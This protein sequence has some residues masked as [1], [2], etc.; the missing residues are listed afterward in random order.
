MKKITILFAILCFAF[1]NQTQA[2]TLTGNSLDLLA[3]RTDLT[4]NITEETLTSG[5]NLTIDYTAPTARINWDGLTRVAPGDIVTVYVEF[6]EEMA[7][8]PIPQISGS[9][10]NT[11]A[12][13][14]LVH[15]DQNRIYTYTWTVG[16]SFGTQYF[17]VSTG[18]DLAGNITEETLTSGGSIL[19]DILPTAALSYTVNGTS[20][21][22]VKQ[23][24]EVL[25]TATFNKD[26]VDIPVVQIYA[27]E[28][29]SFSATNM[30]KISSTSYTYTH[31][32]G[33]GDGNQ[34]FRLAT[35]TDLAGNLINEVPTSGGTLIIDNTAPSAIINWEVTTVNPGNLITINVEFSEEM[36]NSPV[37]QISGSG[38]N[39]FAA[40]DLVHDG[41]N[42][43]KYSWTVED[44]IGLQFFSVSTGTDIAGNLT[45]ETLTSGAS[46]FI[47][48]PASGSLVYTVSGNVED[49]PVQGDVV[50]ITATFNNE[51]DVNHTM[52]IKGTG[53]QSLLGNMERLTSK[54][55]TYT[56][57]VDIG[58]G[59]T[60]F[61]FQNG[62][63][64][65]GNSI[66]YDPS[67]GVSIYHNPSVLNSSHED[68]EL[69]N[70]GAIKINA[71]LVTGDITLSTVPLNDL[72]VQWNKEYLQ[73][74]TTK[75]NTAFNELYD[76]TNWPGFELARITKAYDPTHHG[77]A[78]PGAAL[79]QISA[80]P[81][82]LENYLNVL[83]LDADRDFTDLAG[84]TTL[85]SSTLSSHGA[86]LYID[87]EET[88]FVLTH[89]TGHVVG[90][91]HFAGGWPPE[92]INFVL[93]DGTTM[94]YH[95]LNNS[96]AEINFMG[97]W[98]STMEEYL[99]DPSGALAAGIE[100]ESLYLTK[101]LMTFKTPTFG[102]VSSEV[103]RS[104]LITNEYILASAPNAGYGGH[105]T[106]L[107]VSSNWENEGDN[108]FSSFS[109]QTYPE[110]V[111]SQNET[112][113]YAAI[114]F[115]DT[116][117]DQL[118]Y[119]YRDN[120]SEWGAVT[121]IQGTDGEFQNYEMA[122]NSK[123]DVII[124]TEPSNEGT[125]K[126][127]SKAVDDVS[128]TG[129]LVISDSG[130]NKLRTSRVKVSI[131]AA[132]NAVAVWL[133]RDN[134]GSSDSVT[135]YDNNYSSIV[136]KERIA[137]TWSSAEVLSLDNSKNDLPSIAYNDKGDVLVSW[138]QY[139]NSSN[140]YE[141]V[142]KFRNGT[143]NV[144]SSVES[145]GE[146]NS[147]S[148]F[149]QVAIDV[150]GNALVYWR[151]AGIPEEREIL[152][153][154]P[155]TGF[156]N[157]RYRNLDG[158]LENTTQLTPTEKDAFNGATEQNENRVIFLEDGSAAVTWWVNDGT[159][160]NTIYASSMQSKNVWTT[161]VAL[162]N[163]GH[164]ATLSKIATGN[165]GDYSVIWQR[166]DGLNTR[167][168][169]RTYHAATSNWSAIS[170]LSNSGSNALWGDIASDGDNQLSTI[171]VR[172][173][174]SNW[175][176][177]YI[178]EV[179]RLSL[180][181]FI[182]KTTITADNS[183][184]SVSFNEAVYNTNGAPGSLEANDFTLS[185]SGGTATLASTTP[186]SIS[187]NANVY[188]LGVSFT[189][190]P[191]GTETLTVVP[192]SIGA[193]FDSAGNQAA[194][195]Q[196]NNSIALNDMTT[197]T[198]SLVYTVS[199]DIVRR[200]SENDAVTIT[201]T[202]NKE[203]ADSP[204]VQ[205]SGTGVN[206][207]SASNM[208][209][210]SS[211][212]YTYT[213]TVGEGSG[214]QNFELETGTNLE[215]T[216][217]TA[218]PSSGATIIVVD[219]IVPTA[220]LNYTKDN[221]SVNTVKEGDNILITAIFNEP[222]ADFP[223]VQL[224]SSGVNNMIKRN[225]T[226]VSSTEYIYL[227][228]VGSGNGTQNFIIESATDLGGAVVAPT[229]S[230]G[231][232]IIIDNTKPEFVLAYT[233]D[234]TSVS[235]V[236]AGDEVLITATFDEVMADSPV[237][238]ISGKLSFDWDSIT[239]A[240]SSMIKVSSTKYTYLWTVGSEDG[241]N[242]FD[243]GIG[244]DIA[245]NIVER[246]DMSGGFVTIDNTRPT[247]QINWDGLTRVAPGD[248]VTVYV[249]FSEEM[250]NSPVPQISGSGAN[251]F[252]ATD[253]VHDSQ[254]KIY[255]YAWTVGGNFGTQTFSVSTGTD[256]VGNLTVETLTSGGS[257]TVGTHNTAALSYTVNNNPIQAVKQG[258]EVR[259]TATFN[260]EIRVDPIPQIYAEGL[261][262]FSATNMTR[263]SSTSYTY[264]F[265]AG[266]GDGD[267]NFR[268]ATGLN[269]AGSLINSV[270]SS[271]D[272]LIIDNTK[273]TI[274][275]LGDASIPLE[276]GTSY[277]DDGATAS[278]SRD[279]T[280]TS[281]IITVN[282]V[283]INADGVYT[284][285]YNVSD[286]VGNQ[287]VEVERTVTVVS[288]PEITLTGDALVTVEVGSTYNDEGATAYDDYDG[289]IS[290]IINVV[291]NVNVDALGSY[292]VTYD[293]TDANGNSAVTVTR[294]VN[295]V[296][297]AVPVLPVI[298]LLGNASVFVE[299]GTAYTDAGATASDSTGGI[300][301]SSIVITGT[302]D[303]N[304]VGNYTLFYNVSDAA[305]NPATQVSRT[306]TVVNYSVPVITLLGDAIISLRRGSTY[307]D[308]GAT[309]TDNTDGTITN[310]INT[311]N[312]VNINAFGTYTIT[313]NV[314]NS[315][316]A[317]AIQVTRTVVVQGDEDYCDFS[318]NFENF[319]LTGWTIFNSNTESNNIM[320]TDA[321]SK[322]GNYS[323]R[324]SSKDEDSAYDQYLLSPEFTPSDIEKAI[325]FYYLAS[326]VG[327]VE[328]FKVG[329]STTGNN[330]DTDFT[331]SDEI[332]AESADDLNDMFEYSKDD[333]PIG[334][335]Y[336]A[337]HYYSDNKNHLYI[338]RFCLLA[339][340]EGGYN[341]GITLLGA[342]DVSIELGTTYTDAGAIAFNE[343]GVD[344]TADIITINP[345]DENLEGIYTITYNASDPE[346]NAATEVT[347]TVTVFTSMW[348]GNVDNNWNTAA[349]WSSNAVPS[350]SA[351][352]RIPKT[353]I[354]NFPT[355]LTD[356]NIHAITIESGASLIAAASFSGSLTYK[357]NLYLADSWHFITSPVE[358]TSLADVI[359]NTDLR[360]GTGPNIGIS[361]YDNNVPGWVYH[362][363]TSSG[364]MDS[365]K[366][367][368]V[369]VNSGDIFFTG[370]M[371]IGP[372]DKSLT[373]GQDGWNLI[374]NPY[375]SYLAINNSADAINFLD[376]NSSSL[377]NNFSSIY[378]WDVLDTQS[379]I[380]VVNHATESYDMAPGQ[381]FFVNVDSDGNS[382]SFTNE[383]QSHQAIEN[384]YRSPESTPT[385]VLAI[386]NTEDL[387][388]TTIKYFDSTTAGLDIGY[389][390]G[391][392]NAGGESNFKLNTHLVEDS[393]GIDFMLQC[394]SNNEYETSVVP[395]AVK[396]E[397]GLEI[398]FSV[399]ASNLPE[400]IKVFLEDKTTNTYTRLDEDNSEYIVALTEAENGIGRFYL[401]TKS[402]VLN[403]ND[404]YLNVI[405]IYKKNSSTIRI[406]G[407]AEGTTNF[408]LFNTLGVPVKKTS[409]KAERVFDIEI[410]RLP[411]GI[412]VVQLENGNRIVNKK[413]FLE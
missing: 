71:I 49:Y 69:N 22:K 133:R 61:G 300:I 276:F 388:T 360:T 88:E 206:N 187:S 150:N 379:G 304:T 208:T 322:D 333:L 26:M 301:T 396:A 25:I 152:A 191:N 354:T 84:Q 384:F 352:V 282:T 115:L 265:T 297:A 254:N 224:S 80:Q 271:G 163:S 287:A 299:L 380:K 338:D 398:V 337:I 215:G 366:G 120:N 93:Q 161:P 236:T 154:V 38:A 46:I 312:P 395:L 323:L 225:M 313:Y 402:S 249:E 66:T 319:P 197:H 340:P 404:P 124:I 397:A 285:T 270:P 5:K 45:E 16:Q 145:Y 263:I 228:T 394:L 118:N 342:E 156:L 318:E 188:T 121:T 173:N 17:S 257:I 160:P 29:N 186:T 222:M 19:I 159:N 79:S 218:T 95:T 311:V 113:N 27:E 81:V 94:G 387:E 77:T 250:A 220:A 101:P 153:A 376:V 162:S 368:A 204:I 306:V 334:T 295:V 177:Y 324:F 291:S 23:G 100:T 286:A 108:V 371:P 411:A 185:I 15:D 14:D 234:G 377:S 181:P 332:I 179:K 305:G 303:N 62:K 50:T 182:T 82:A 138:Q 405:S 343:Q 358:G 157:V 277:T 72:G 8:S 294:T 36:A 201:A 346:G 375:P 158:S 165:G 110:I 248:V 31:T 216:V 28:L 238:Q 198:A 39:T 253:L 274:E 359:S 53:A 56:Y 178:P 195:M 219:N 245:G 289:N 194:T 362:S 131:N 251:T 116:T 132:G 96:Q 183:A 170:T 292:T 296:A 11:I 174:G 128:W 203:I 55:Y 155:R 357:R 229:P 24:D 329:W 97:A 193:I 98:N 143:T 230:S 226:K 103:F 134:D 364:T 51:I 142:G 139:N 78:D 393:E 217:I 386:D 65:Y 325:S 151:Q 280:I 314:S 391:A 267:Q 111:T 125:I 75:M 252:A 167:I 140:K 223:F 168:Q 42:K 403:I 164:N 92:N 109:R 344:I 372:I 246:S 209:K 214:V 227:W 148:G 207:I 10:A 147:S 130:M 211:K 4:G 202:F 268:L 382:V 355:A 410:P 117:N 401:H 348:N 180:N 7:N 196:N 260:Q 76:S 266:S 213:W 122:M 308:A 83:V 200:V 406:V 400:G 327:E 247:A 339:S 12:V 90:L 169:T 233:I 112:N 310:H 32:A 105:D 302:V 18:T 104:W 328:V 298:R 365:A 269:E 74:I 320:L 399:E 1:F 146:T 284:I 239:L 33:L 232:S 383:M 330:L 205:I 107:S 126:V 392:F 288:V 412:Y 353:G 60:S 407:L 350:A 58:K 307:V 242:S 68:F 37:P 235:R 40:T 389:D 341:S 176:S 106:S 273:P 279:G 192:A 316:G 166:A 52:Q 189:G 345:V 141:V 409:F 290:A 119:S 87:N 283:N 221:S 390:A 381:G 199:G 385:I 262:S 47:S 35:G 326:D 99:G 171:W 91:P 123:G 363:T 272:G 378:L 317:P 278:D 331:W 70:P 89:E 136:F 172:K 144:W 356:V 64:I 184:I 127:F 21:S 413:L 261:N 374:G 57:T 259:I 86:T 9:G 243:M 149:S 102:A 129:P 361:N 48:N 408:K 237:P 315:I 137:G 370:T 258:D 43:Y 13:T 240:A 349:N 335:K 351:S 59:V 212:E 73:E 114:G 54:T 175:D 241:Q 244:T 264:T 63:D 367:Y 321:T 256:I 336:V 210:V 3:N 369:L 347:R 67:S 275:L 85:N 190:I 2:L 6:S 293:V 255:T 41:G 373:L 20:V 135:T 231:A 44:S 281:N 34:N 30:T 309:A